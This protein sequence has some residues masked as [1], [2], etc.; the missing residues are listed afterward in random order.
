[1]KTELYES[2]IKIRTL[3]YPCHI[4]CLLS[5]T[6]EC[7]FPYPNVESNYKH[8][9]IATCSVDCDLQTSF[10]LSFWM[11]TLYR[12]VLQISMIRLAISPGSA[13]NQGLTSVLR[14]FF[15]LPVLLCPTTGNK[16]FVLFLRI[17]VFECH[18]YNECF[19][20]S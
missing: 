9:S 11:L 4:V 13:I 10:N 2:I 19:L 8:K 17:A 12:W 7:F 18:D 15:F 16:A 1:M 6:S 14:W 5:Q 3:I 20:S